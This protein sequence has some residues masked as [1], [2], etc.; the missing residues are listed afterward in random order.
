MA[1]ATASTTPP[2]PPARNGTPSAGSLTR[3]SGRRDPRAPDRVAGEAYQEPPRD[4]VA[5]H[6]GSL[7]WRMIAISAIW[8]V[9]LLLGGGLALD[10]TLTNLVQ[11]NFDTQLNNNLTALIASA[12]IQPGGEVWQIG[13]ASCR[14]R[15]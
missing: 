9:V 3:P 7:T 4:F 12:E 10:R 1:L 2:T 14:E 11:G 8:I 5:P 13:R 6:T 15:V